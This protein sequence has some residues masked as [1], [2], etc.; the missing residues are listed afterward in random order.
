MT[1]SL[2]HGGI[3]E[4]LERPNPIVTFAKVWAEGRYWEPKFGDRHA[5]L[6][7][8]RKMPDKVS[9]IRAYR[10]FRAS[11]AKEEKEL[12]EGRAFLRWLQRHEI[13]VEWKQRDFE[14][15]PFFSHPNA[16]KHDPK[17]EMAEGLSFAI[18]PVEVSGR[19]VKLYVG[20]DDMLNLLSMPYGND[21]DFLELVMRYVAQRFEWEGWRAPAPPFLD[22][23]KSQGMRPVFVPGQL[24]F[25]PTF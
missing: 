20:D 24:G 19:K 11:G 13:S 8:R 18:R 1:N 17:D 16:P 21:K 22:W 4:V 23:V 5:L 14:P 15:H 2:I 12:G 25:Q 10:G 7:L 3:S 6:L 9:F